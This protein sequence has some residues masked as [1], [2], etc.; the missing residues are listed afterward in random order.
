[1]GKKEYYGISG[2]GEYIL[3]TNDNQGNKNTELY[4]YSTK[5]K[6][7]ID[8]IAPYFFHSWQGNHFEYYIKTAELTG[9]AEKSSRTKAEKFIWSAGKSKNTGI[10]EEIKNEQNE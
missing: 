5:T 4:I 9:G 7:V 6:R 1:M 2:N 3:Y 8:K 10:F